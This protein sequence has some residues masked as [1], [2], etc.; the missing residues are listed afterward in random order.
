[1]HILLLEGKEVLLIFSLRFWASACS[2]L[3][4]II[5]KIITMLPL[6]VLTQCFST[7]LYCANV[8]FGNIH[9]VSG[10]I[11]D[12]I[13]NVPL[14]LQSHPRLPVT[15]ILLLFLPKR[16]MRPFTKQAHEAAT[17]TLPPPLCCDRSFFLLWGK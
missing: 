3:C 7:F 1:M 16:C 15:L 17:R 13:E 5:L 4:K 14:L 10:L 11:E 6:S 12:V 8:A 9:I 2:N